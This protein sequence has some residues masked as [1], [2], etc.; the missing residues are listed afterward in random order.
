[1]RAGSQRLGIRQL[2]A[3]P[4]YKRHMQHNAA[5]RGTAQHSAV[6]FNALHSGPLCFRQPT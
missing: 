3:R 2:V 5:H 6:Q 1:M 4:N